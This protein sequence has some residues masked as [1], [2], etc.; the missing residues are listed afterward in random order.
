MASKKQEILAAQAELFKQQEEAKA[1]KQ[2]EKKKKKK[3]EMEEQ[4]NV[5]LN[6][7]EIE[8]EQKIVRDE[9]IK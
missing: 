8:Q 3:L 5:L 6:S 4:K 7:K 1:K 9:K 2:E